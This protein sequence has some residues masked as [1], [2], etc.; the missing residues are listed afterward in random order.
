MSTPAMQQSQVPAQALEPGPKWLAFVFAS[1]VLMFAFSVEAQQAVYR[2]GQEITNQPLD[3][4]LCQQLSTSQP[5]QI[6]GTRVQASSQQALGRAAPAQMGSSV[7]AQDRQLQARTILEDE[8]QRLSVQYAELVQAYNRG[9]PMPLA[10]ESVHQPNYQQ[11]A[12]SLK[13]QLFRME[14]DMQALQRE[15]SRYGK[16]MTTV[17]SK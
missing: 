1:V 16:R 9:Q 8:W 15:L 2:C 14:R 17:Q 4:L 12:Q 10:G 7:E 5:T 3:P 6:E 11:R 13:V